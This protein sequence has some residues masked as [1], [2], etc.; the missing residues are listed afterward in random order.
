VGTCASVFVWVKG[1]SRVARTMYEA[2]VWSSHRLRSLGVGQ[3]NVNWCIYIL[4]SGKS[5]LSQFN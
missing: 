5:L 1:C 2:V 4:P 3:V